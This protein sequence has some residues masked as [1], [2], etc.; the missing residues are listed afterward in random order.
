MLVVG[1]YAANQ[2]Q[3]YL[4][5]AHISE[6][7]IVRVSAVL[8]LFRIPCVV[9]VVFSPLRRLYIFSGMHGVC[10]FSI[11]SDDK[12]NDSNSRHCYLFFTL[13]FSARTFVSR[14]SFG[15]VCKQFWLLH[16][17]EL[18]ASSGLRPG[19]LLNTLWCPGQPPQQ[20]YSSSNVSSAVVEKPRFLQYVVGTGI[21]NFYRIS[22]YIVSC[23]H[24]ILYTQRN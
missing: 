15:N 9:V 11:A 3:F 2:D 20:S 4:L 7:I 14:G 13:W 12:D 19:M 17:G 16:L 21:H 5:S 8:W 23:L 24:Y 10:S 1:L 22:F 18:L 6:R